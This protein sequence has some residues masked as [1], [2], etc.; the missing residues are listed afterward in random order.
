VCMQD[1]NSCQHLC[2]RDKELW[3]SLSSGNVRVCQCSVTTSHIKD[4]TESIAHHISVA[5]THILPLSLSLSH[6]SVSHS[7]HKQ[8]K[9][10]S[11]DKTLRLR[12]RCFAHAPRHRPPL[13]MPLPL[14]LPLPVPIPVPLPLFD[15]RLTLWS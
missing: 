10:S 5:H 1:D 7:D 8:T 9:L 3:G 11:F 6:Y 13:V 2:S 14:S 15:F 12:S 4:I